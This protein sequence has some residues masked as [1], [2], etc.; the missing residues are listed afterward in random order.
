MC[1]ICLGDFVEC[2][3]CKTNC[4]HFY[5]KECLDAW[6]NK[7]K[8]SCPMCRQPITYFCYNGHNHRIIK[9]VD[10]RRNRHP[11]NPRSTTVIVNKSMVYATMMLSMGM[12]SANIILFGLWFTCDDHHP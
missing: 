3:L 1:S 2:E 10:S 6:F 11:M 9:L 7:N 12:L 8:D 5:C 4:N